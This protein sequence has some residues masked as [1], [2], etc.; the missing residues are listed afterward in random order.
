MNE[1]LAAMNDSALSLAKGAPPQSAHCLRKA[2]DLSSGP[3]FCDHLGV[4]SMT[5]SRVL[6]SALY[7]DDKRL[8]GTQRQY[9]AA[10]LA[11]SA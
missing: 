5:H 9:K 1:S 2:A 3:L 7:L 8:Q 11:T 6:E 10:N 4:C